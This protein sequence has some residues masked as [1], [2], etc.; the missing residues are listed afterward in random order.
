MADVSF[1]V[2]QLGYDVKTAADNE[3]LFNSSWPLL[4]VAYEGDF[5][6][7]SDVTQSIYAH[8]LGYP[9]A[10]FVNDYTNGYAT[11]NP[12]LNETL[13]INNNQL[14][15]TTG[16]VSLT[17]PIKIHYYIYLLD[18]TKSYTGP[19]VKQSFQ[20]PGADID[21]V[22]LK[23]AKPNK[24]V[25]SY[26]Y[27]D[28]TIHSGTQ[29]P[30]IHMVVNQITQSTNAGGQNIQAIVAQHNLGYLPLFFPFVSDGKGN[31][32]F[33]GNFTQSVPRVFGDTQHTQ[34]ELGLSGVNVNPATIVVFKDPYSVDTPNI[35]V[36]V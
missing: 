27:R 25:S 21:N 33:T 26:D 12:T 36:T 16:I 19:I 35:S 3:L 30:M 4:K 13:S 2:S 24:N 8:N 23:V 9:A 15:Y 29:S 1:K 17:L 10:F 32:S 34:I 5:I 28:Y 22:V 6:L 20:V 14:Q 7:N 31:Y 11:S 18:L